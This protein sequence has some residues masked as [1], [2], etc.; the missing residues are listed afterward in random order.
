MNINIHTYTERL[1]FYRLWVDSPRK[2]QKHKWTISIV[3][4][5]NALINMFNLFEEIKKFLIRFLLKQ[6]LFPNNIIEQGLHKNQD[7]TK[8][9]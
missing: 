8:K 9:I 7:Y 4:P 1:I 5:V 3:V 2:E 6:K